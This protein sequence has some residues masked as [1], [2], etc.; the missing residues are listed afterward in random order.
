MWAARCQRLNA[1]IMQC[2]EE[3]PTLSHLKYQQGLAMASR[4][5]IRSIMRL[6][7]FYA[8]NCPITIVRV[9]SQLH[10]GGKVGGMDMR[11][12]QKP[13]WLQVLEELE[14]H[15]GSDVSDCS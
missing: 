2:A 9:V 15:C 13:S 5:N 11:A 12:L 7:I 3:N 6:P 10:K 1:R 4:R 8:H 14:F